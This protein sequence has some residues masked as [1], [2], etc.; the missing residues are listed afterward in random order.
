VGTLALVI[1]AGLILDELGA[2][3]PL[4]GVLMQLLRPVQQL[5][6]GLADRVIDANRTLRRARDLQTR[7]EQL[8]SL[9][10]QLM[11]ENVRLKEFEAQNEDLRKKLNFAETH[12]EYILRAAQVKGRVIA[13]EPNNLLS[14]LIIDVGRRHGIKR[15]MPVVT[16]RGLVGHIQTVGTNWAKVLLINDPSS[17]VAAM[18][19]AS[20][21]PGV[22]AGRLAEDLVMNYIPQDEKVAVGD[23]VVTSGMG[24]NYPKALVIGQVLEVERRDI[25]TFQRAVVHPSVNFERLET[26]LVIT[27]FD[28]VDVTE[29]INGSQQQDTGSSTPLQDTDQTPPSTPATGRQED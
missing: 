2:L 24:G 7:N 14:I 16:E 1:V 13:S 20:R 23:I 25:E 5:T 17:S 15:R 12:P 19:Q 18:I 10:D 6:S 21:A 3:A 27:S 9:V 4:E 28:T 26:V 11:V 22:V 8:E 29:A